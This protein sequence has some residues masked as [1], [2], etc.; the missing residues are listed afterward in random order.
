MDKK[1]V[2]MFA[3]QGNPQV[4]KKPSRTVNPTAVIVSVVVLVALAIFVVRPA[5]LGYGIYQEAQA[6]NLDVQDYAQNMQQLSKDLEV[7]KTNLSTYSTFT[8]ALITQIDKKSTEIT[9]CKVQLER[10]KADLEIAQKQVADK[11][12][13]I[14]TVKT[15]SQKIVDQQVTEKTAGLE[16]S[17]VECEASLADKET[18][19]GAAQAK[20]D[21]LLKNAAKSICCKTKVDNPQINF[22]DVVDGKII[23]LEQGP[24][25]LSC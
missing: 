22:Y 7:T 1:E 11:E 13:E 21:Q 12:V 15:E 8:G 5:V 14:T 6:S 20:Y 3:N 4:K 17:K 25:Q 16:Q 2:E 10:T 19:I 9:E 18:E 24:N 23:C